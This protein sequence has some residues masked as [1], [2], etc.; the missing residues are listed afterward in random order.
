METLGT[1]ISDIIREIN[2]LLRHTRDL[3]YE[4]SLRKI[5]R[6]YFALL[7]KIT[8]QEIDS[9]THEFKD[10]IKSL[11]IARSTIEEAIKDITKTAD[12]INKL[13]SAAKVIDKVAKVGVNLLAA[14]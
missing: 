9:Q 13:E 11:A 10:A 6:I 3:E 5:R 4:S 2:K 7:E 14:H 1:E 8:K 12:T